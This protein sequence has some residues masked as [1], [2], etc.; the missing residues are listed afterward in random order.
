MQVEGD[1]A[2]VVLQHL[3]EVGHA[4]IPRGRIP[5]P[6]PLH[7]IE[8]PAIGHA[9]QGAP[10]HLRQPLVPSPAPSVFQEQQPAG[11]GVGELGGFAKAPVNRIVVPGD[12]ADQVQ[13]DGPGEPGAGP[14][15]RAAEGLAPAGDLLGPPPD[16]LPAGPVVLQDLKEHLTHLVG[17]D[18]GAAGE[19]L[20]IRGQEDGGGPPAHVIAGVD[21]RPAIGVHPDGNEIGVDEFGDL[22]IRVGAGVDWIAGEAA[23]HDVTPV[24]PGGRDAEQDRLVLLLRLPE[25]LFSP[26]PPA[27]PALPHGPS[28]GFRSCASFSSYRRRIRCATFPRAADPFGVN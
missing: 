27:H 6:T 20:A 15:H 11:V 28:R 12:Q 18:V 7:R 21:V 1:E 3:L 14:G 2:G 4:P 8:H 22:W 25:G 26:L 24:A 10:D 5:E 13:G 9:V 23:V 17:R 19:D 16:L